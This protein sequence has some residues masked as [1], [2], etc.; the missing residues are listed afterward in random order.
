MGTHSSILV[1]EI[2]GQ[3]SLAG[4]SLRG[5]KELDVTEQLNNIIF[6]GKSMNAFSQ[7]YLSGREDRKK[8]TKI[9][10][11]TTAAQ[12]CMQDPSQSN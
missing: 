9:S 7:R 4:Y 10:L 5:R 12:H 3:R 6:N 2:R 8:K 11:L 1:W